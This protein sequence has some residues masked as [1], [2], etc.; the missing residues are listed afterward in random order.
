M[1]KIGK[2][3]R[4]RI[5]PPAQKSLPSNVAFNLNDKAFKWSLRA[6]IWE[7]GGWLKCKDPKFFVDH[8]ISKLQA[9]ETQKWQDILDSS[10]GKSIGHGNNNHFVLASQLPQ[11]EKRA[12]IQLEYME[13]FEKVFSLRLSG[14]ERLIGIVDMSRFDILWYDPEHNF[15]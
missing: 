1:N 2:H 5:A 15:F 8:I 10:G 3:G 12:F 4:K 13:R 14:K 11:K 6:A 7:H 9:L